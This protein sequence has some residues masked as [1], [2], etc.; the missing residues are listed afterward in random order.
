M[1][2]MDAECVAHAVFSGIRTVTSKTRDICLNLCGGIKTCLFPQSE[3]RMGATDGY[4]GKGEV[5]K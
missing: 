2:S 5:R 1:V 3:N 4:A